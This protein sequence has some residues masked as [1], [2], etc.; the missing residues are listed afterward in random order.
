ML[1]WNY[2][3]WDR[4]DESGSLAHET[5]GQATQ[6]LATS[7]ALL[8]MAP[9]GFVRAWPR[10]WAHA[11]IDALGKD[12][13]GREMAGGRSDTRSRIGHTKRIAEDSGGKPRPRQPN[14]Y[15]FDGELTP[16]P[17]HSHGILLQVRLHT[18]PRPRPAPCRPR[19]R[20]HYASGAP[21]PP[22]RQGRFRPR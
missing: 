19:W 1:G 14:R 4:P 18:H 6:P 17:R 9:R 21:R 10:R 13:I 5:D 8:R 2:D 12:W 3:R 7:S 22:T 20:L 11:T 16:P 15:R